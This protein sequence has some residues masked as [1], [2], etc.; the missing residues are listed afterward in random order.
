[1]KKNRAIREISSRLQ[2]AATPACLALV[3]LLCVFSLLPFG[4]LSACA[5][6]ALIAA[7]GHTLDD[8]ALRGP[9]AEYWLYDDPWDYFGMLMAN[10]NAYSNND[11][12]GVAAYAEN[13]PKLSASG[14][15]YKRVLSFSDLNRVYYTGSY[16]NPDVHYDTEDGDVLDT[17]L[18]AIRGGEGQPVIVLGHVR[19]ASGRTLGNHP[20]F[21][22]YQKRTFSFMHNGF[23][24][25]ARA[26]MIARIRQADPYWFNLHPNNHFQDPDPLNWVDT[27][28]LFHYIMSHVVARDGDVLSGLNHALLGLRSYLDSPT[29]GIYNFVMSDGERLYVYRSTPRTG[30]NSGYK[31]SYRSFGGQF[32]AVRTL[33]PQPGDTELEGRELVV[34][35]RGRKPLHYPDFARETVYSSAL[36]VSASQTRDRPEE[37]VPAIVAGPNPFRGF[38]TLRISVANSGELV[39]TVCNAK[40]Q[41][42]WSR[43]RQIDRPGTI[44]V[45]WDG[46]DDRGKPLAPGI[47]FIKA[48]TDEKRLRARVVLLK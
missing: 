33:G 35:D 2:S 12:Y 6:S 19:S 14:M 9:A 17:A 11:G 21:F 45:I 7:R 42:V 3:T 5:M 30:A 29:S 27:E 31:L 18:N 15:W 16:L 36:G 44:S 1:M 22:G 38:T 34:F 28:V 43:S 20:F 4:S 40:G 13:Q 24:D 39:T 46:K 32:Y 47:Y 37:I 26:F 41:P 48:E 23:C 8:F 10:S 25:S